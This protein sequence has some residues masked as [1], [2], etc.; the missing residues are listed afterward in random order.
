MKGLSENGQPFFVRIFRILFYY[1]G[2]CVF[3]QFFF[4]A[5]YPVDLRT[6]ALL[7]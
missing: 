2:F 1:S 7:S 4:S 3:P 6:A 5:P